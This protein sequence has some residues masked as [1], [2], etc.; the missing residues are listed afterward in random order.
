MT[1][2]VAAN[3]PQVQ[4]NLD[5]LAGSKIFSS[6]DIMAAYYITKL[7]EGH[8][9]YASFHCPGKGAFRFCRA[10]MGLKSS[11]AWFINLT[12]TPT[13]YASDFWQ[14]FFQHI[15]NS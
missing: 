14:N 15:T 4:D 13:R 6:V 10:S 11:Q 8:R 12:I 2:P 7:Y 3:L 1:I 5:V 9:D